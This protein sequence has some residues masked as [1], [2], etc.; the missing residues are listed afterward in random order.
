VP[1]AFRREIAEFLRDHPGPICSTCIATALALPLRQ[2]TM[3]T[4][5]LHNCGGFAMEPN[6]S[7]SSCGRRG[8]VIQAVAEK[9][10]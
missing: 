5:G 3:T 9:P 2:V 8:R 6:E 7:C 4:L 10:A 1:V